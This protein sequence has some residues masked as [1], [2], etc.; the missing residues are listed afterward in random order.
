MCSSRGIPPRHPWLGFDHPATQVTP[1]GLQLPRRLSRGGKFR[2]AA[3][4]SSPT[5]RISGAQGTPGYPT[6]RVD[7]VGRVRPR[8]GLRD[9]LIGLDRIIAT[10]DLKRLSG[11]YGFFATCPGRSQG[12]AR[13]LNT[14]SGA[15]GQAQTGLILANGTVRSRGQSGRW[16]FHG[17]HA[18]LATALLCSSS[19]ISRKT[20][21]QTHMVVC[22]NSR[23]RGYQ[24]V[25]SPSLIHRQSPA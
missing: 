22:L 17:D 25:R 10:C 8:R 7:P 15:S 6:D 21:S 3:R 13:G 20:L 5:E 19:A 11:F 4:A 14:T 1:P 12:D 24:G 9:R 18:T 23:I 16:V 2:H